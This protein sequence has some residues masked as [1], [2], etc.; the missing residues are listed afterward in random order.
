[1]T[2]RTPDR[3]EPVYDDGESLF[4]TAEPNGR[5]RRT[6]SWRSAP[7]AVL[8]IAGA[9]TGLLAA[10]SPFD[11][12]RRLGRRGGGARQPRSPRLGMSGASP[13]AVRSSPTALRSSVHPRR[14]MVVPSPAPAPAAVVVGAGSESPPADS[15]VEFGFER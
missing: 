14:S 9:T 6:R 1:M 5:T 3:L 8:A 13:R 10:R 7:F 12:A 4:G 11:T 2:A 15:S